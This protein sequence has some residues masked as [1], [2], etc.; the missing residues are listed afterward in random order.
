MVDNEIMDYI[1]VFR[2]IFS[3][4]AHAVLSAGNWHE[5]DFDFKSAHADLEKLVVSALS[6]RRPD[7]AES[8]DLA[9]F[10]V[11][12]WLDEKVAGLR[13]HGFGEIGESMQRR[14]FNTVNAGEEFFEKLETLL[15]ADNEAIPRRREIVDV[16]GSCLELGFL[17]RYFRL[18]DAPQI[19]AYR[20]RCLEALADAGGAGRRNMLFQ[21]YEPAETAASKPANMLVFWIIPIAVTL[22]LFAV[23]R[24]LLADLFAGITG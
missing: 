15:E 9:W 23:Y 21:S 4:G 19:A 8:F 24:L 13:V 16:Y 10:A 7:E 12:A 1:D 20:R 3:F 11:C 14:F 6:R 5:G 22:G 18:E 17:G 2:P